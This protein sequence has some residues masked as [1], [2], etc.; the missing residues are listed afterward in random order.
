MG[1]AK[2]ANCAVRALEPLGCRHHGK[3]FSDRGF[4]AAP[5]RNQDCESRARRPPLTQPF[6]HGEFCSIRHAFLS[7]LTERVGVSLQFRD[8]SCEP[9]VE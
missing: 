9:P 2:C 8:E 1:A 7:S 3:S 5:A 6:S 4:A